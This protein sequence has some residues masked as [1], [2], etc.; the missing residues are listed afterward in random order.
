M[1]VWN[2]ASIYNGVE[3]TNDKNT[4]P[5]GGSSPSS[6]S[7]LDGIYRIHAENGHTASRGGC[8]QVMT[9]IAYCC[10]ENFEGIHVVMRYRQGFG[11]GI[12]LGGPCRLNRSTDDTTKERPDQTPKMNHAEKVDRK[13]NIN[14][15]GQRFPIDSL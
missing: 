10:R 1:R 8:R 9:G 12:A 14:G 3:M 7:Y 13:E 4:F 2:D 15:A 5:V 11:R 6:S